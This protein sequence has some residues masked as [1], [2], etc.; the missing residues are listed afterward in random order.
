MTTEMKVSVSTFSLSLF[1]VLVPITESTQG[2]QIPPNIADGIDAMASEATDRLGEGGLGAFD[3]NLESMEEELG[4]E[5]SE[6]LVEK[7]KYETALAIAEEEGSMLFYEFANGTSRYLW[8]N[9][10]VVSPE[11][12]NPS[13]E[14]IAGGIEVLGGDVTIQAMC[15][16]T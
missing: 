1:M 8:P 15:E 5:F 4:T 16:I 7:L 3:E 14:D 2:Q 12:E 6:P 13:C 9:G 11:P 10:D